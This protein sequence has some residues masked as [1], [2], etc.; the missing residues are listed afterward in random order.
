MPYEFFIALR[1]LR[2]KRKQVMISVITII[3]IA[4]V[5]MGVA[6]LIVVLAMMT[7]FRQEFQAKI[8]SGTAHLNL[9]LKERKRSKT[10]ESSFVVSTPF[11]YSSCFGNS[12]STRVDPGSEGY[13]GRNSERVD[14]SAPVTQTRSSNLC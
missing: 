14:V 11:P 13:R 10:I 7:G 8:L 6:S 3:A 2:A 12:I 1:Y 5:S 4:A 9:T